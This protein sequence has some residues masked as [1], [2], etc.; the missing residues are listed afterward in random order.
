[1]KNLKKLFGIVSIIAIIA[2][3]MAACELFNDKP[4]DQ[5]PV[6]GDYDIGN[7]KQS[8]NNV[9]AVTI[10]PK[11]GKSG[12][13]RTI[14]YEGTGGSAKSITIPQND[15]AY[16]VTFDVAAASG[17]NAASGLYAGTLI[18]GIP[19][20]VAGDF[21]ISNLTQTA[22][23]VKAVTITPM[24]GRS[25]GK[26]KI[27]Y[28]GIEDTNYPKSDKF[29]ENGTV[30][31]EYAV[32]F[33]VA[34]ATGWKAATGLSAGTLV[35]NDNKT[36]EV[37]HYD[38]S[39]WGTHIYDGNKKTVTVERKSKDNRESSPG[40]VTVKYGDDSSPPVNGK[41]KVYLDVEEATGWNAAILTADFLYLDITPAG[42]TGTPAMTVEILG[43][44]KV[45]NTLH[46]DVVKNF[47]GQTTYKWKIDGVFD[48]YETRNELYLDI[49][50]AG[51]KIA[52]EVKCGTLTKESAP[53]IIV[54]MPP[55]TAE[56][57]TSVFY[58]DYQGKFYETLYVTVKFDGNEW[59][60][61]PYSN[62]GF[63]VKWLRNGAVISEETNYFY[64]VTAADKGATITA[65]VSGHGQTRTTANG[66]KVAAIEYTKTNVPARS[67]DYIAQIVR[68]I[69]IAY[70]VNT[71]YSGKPGCRDLIDGV[72][73]PW[74]VDFYEE[75]QDKKTE[76]ND[77]IL[78][79]NFSCEW[80]D[81]A[82]KD[83]SEGN[84]ITAVAVY[85][86]IW[87]EGME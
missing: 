13:A 44:A 66:Y 63:S 1:M 62:S 25:T 3:T 15:G 72:G 21:I 82:F 40:R 68:E 64:N 84:R 69:E 30:G 11:A 75:E 45:G 17:W 70:K 61:T 14:Y 32:T 60:D 34:E 79:I 28:T 22:G 49:E 9:T 27:W 31:S 83:S 35:I 39:G 50:K 46:A 53:A 87:V 55:Y 29:P 65:E 54:Q 78:C 56:L 26:I 74:R 47:G 77:G 20:P 36:P 4:Q 8:S 24:E 2:C 7:L 37:G 38:I 80:Y 85:L 16:V 43:D 57:Q 12:G 19:I 6:A 52:V 48:E 59:G 71:R 33:D 5:T 86:G 10:T 76:I 67:D 42:S 51:K 81:D 73:K 23:K 18:V 41:C 58:N